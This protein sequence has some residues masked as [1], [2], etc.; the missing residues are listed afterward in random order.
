MMNDKF[1]T[2]SREYKEIQVR[3]ALDAKDA[4]DFFFESTQIDALGC[5]TE[6]LILK[7]IVKYLL[8]TLQRRQEGFIINNIALK[9]KDIKEDLIE[10]GQFINRF[11][12]QY[13]KMFNGIN[14][15]FTLYDLTDHDNKS[16]YGNA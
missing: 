6:E 5:F 10:K 7:F 11:I 12:M 8:V 13:R 16:E 9:I 1:D 4:I 15:Y 2:P 3:D 14:A